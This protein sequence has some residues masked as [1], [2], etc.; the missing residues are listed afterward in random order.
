MLLAF[1]FGQ[2]KENEIYSIGTRVFFGVFFGVF[3]LASFEN[4]RNK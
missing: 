2:K 4:K 3:F 1:F